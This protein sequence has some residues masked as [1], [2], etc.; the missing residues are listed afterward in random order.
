MQ[1]LPDVATPCSS[2]LL[3]VDPPL[4]TAFLLTEAI[5]ESKDNREPLFVASLD[6]EKV[7]DTVQHNSLLDKLH[8]LG[9]QGVCWLLKRD[10][11]QGLASQTMWK[12][13]KS[14][15]LIQMKQ[16]NGQGKTTSPDDFISHLH[17]LLEMTSEGYLGYNIRSTCISTPTCADEMLMLATNI[18]ELQAI[19]QL[20]EYYANDEHYNIHLPSP[21]WSY[22][23]PNPI[24]FSSIGSKTVPSP[25]TARASQ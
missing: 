23:I 17:N 14:A 16:G 15:N 7:F 13:E 5:A 10:S 6:F 24:S 3:R 4:H 18:E 12:G 2:D 21:R 11:Y 1:P 19:I 8:Q 22:S 9:V 25:S 20:I